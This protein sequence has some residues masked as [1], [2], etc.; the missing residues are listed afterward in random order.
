MTEPD[1]IPEVSRA[2]CTCCQNRGALPGAFVR[3]AF[4]RIK[5]QA[6]PGETIRAMCSACI[7]GAFFGGQHPHDLAGLRRAEREANGGPV[8]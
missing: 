8:R 3:D 1:T 2:D 7:A 4:G 6:V 5:S